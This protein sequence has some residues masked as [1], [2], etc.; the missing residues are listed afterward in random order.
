MTT[1]LLA[2]GS[3]DARHSATLERLRSRVAPRLRRAGHGPTDLCY[4]EHDAPG[5]EEL[6]ARLTGQ[7]TLVPLLL[8]PALHARVDVPAAAS[9][10]GRGGAHVRQAEAL[11]G[12]PLLLEAV[13]ERIRAAG[14][15][16]GEPVLLVAGGSRS[17]QAG[18]SLRSLLE[19]HPRPGWMTMTLA[20]PRAGATAGR[21]VVPATLAE[22]VLHDRARDLAEGAGAPFVPGG[23]ADTD[24]LARLVALRAGP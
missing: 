10:L 17:G 18:Q 7:V 24:A 3:P 14:R 5:P 8:T 22:G 2:H 19:R 4:I 13:E 6:G 9:R 15:D 20:A 23:L 21:T 11:G 12:H 1:V 16:P